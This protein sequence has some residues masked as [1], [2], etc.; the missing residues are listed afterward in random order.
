MNPAQ[1]MK[2]NKLEWSKYKTNFQLWKKGLAIKQYATEKHDEPH[3]IGIK[4]KTGENLKSYTYILTL[5]MQPLYIVIILFFRVYVYVRFI[6]LIY[7]YNKTILGWRHLFE[8]LIVLQNV[9][10]TI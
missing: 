6:P 10:G 4:K 5:F 1:Q 3:N 9:Y 8:F 2:W 7:I